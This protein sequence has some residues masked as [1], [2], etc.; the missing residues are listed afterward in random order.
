MPFIKRNDKVYL[1][2][3]VEGYIEKCEN[4]PFMS[5]KILDDIDRLKKYNLLPIRRLDKAKKEVNDNKVDTDIINNTKPFGGKHK[6]RYSN[7]DDEFDEITDTIRYYTEHIEEMEE[8][9]ELENT[10]HTEEQRKT[11]KIVKA[12]NE[13][14]N[15]G[16]KRGG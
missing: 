14:L 12:L 2:T 6:P 8:V 10:Y 15:K 3:S 1:I 4:S 9:I 11:L 16:K 7:A 13:E 5:K